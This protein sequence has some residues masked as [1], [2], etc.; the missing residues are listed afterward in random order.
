MYTNFSEL[1]EEARNAIVERLEEGYEGYTCDFHN[2][3]FNTN[4]YECYTSEAIRKLESMGVFDAIEAVKEYEQDNFG[5]ADTDFSD[6][7]AILNMLWYIVGEEE[8]YDMFNGC[9]EWDEW[10]DEKISETECK[11][12]LGW[13]K[14]NERI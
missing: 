4:Y 12:L 7:C 1:R 10:W 13:L 8:L 3:V 2:E 5:T 11:I 6:P 9:E 14:D